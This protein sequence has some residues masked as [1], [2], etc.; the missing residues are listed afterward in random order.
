MGSTIFDVVV[1]QNKA[2][3]SDVW[4]EIIFFPKVSLMKLKKKKGIS[5]RVLTERKFD[6]LN[7][8]DHKIQFGNAINESIEK[9]C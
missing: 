8:W 1:I 2:L 9:W 7:M 4:F 5:C 3:K 6:N